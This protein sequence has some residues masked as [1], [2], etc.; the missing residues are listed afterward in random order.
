MY[1]INTYSQNDSFSQPSNALILQALSCNLIVKKLEIHYLAHKIIYTKFDHLCHV[2]LSSNQL[3]SLHSNAS[4]LIIIIKTIFGISEAS[5]TEG[6]QNQ[7]PSIR[8]ASCR[9]CMRGDVTL[10][11]MKLL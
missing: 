5:S 2:R 10:K 1:I 9:N 8:V 6:F 4:I 7:E 11:H 3:Y